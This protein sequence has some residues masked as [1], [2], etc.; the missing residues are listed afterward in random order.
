M[1]PFCT[2]TAGSKT[3]SEDGGRPPAVCVLADATTTASSTDDIQAD[4]QAQPDTDE[5]QVA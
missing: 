5:T 1:H 4:I 2:F 3:T